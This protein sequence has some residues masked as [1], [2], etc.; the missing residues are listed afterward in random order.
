MKLN[1]LTKA[2]TCV[3]SYDLTRCPKCAEKVCFFIENDDFY[4]NDFSM[5]GCESCIDINILHG[6]STLIE[7]IEDWFNLVNKFNSEKEIV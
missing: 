4:H 5:F 2:L 1:E 7:V 3:D 6:T